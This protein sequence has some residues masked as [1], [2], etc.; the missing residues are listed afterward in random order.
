MIGF[1]RDR[2]KIQKETKE[3]G[4]FGPTSSW[5][6]VGVPFWAAMTDISTDGRARYQQ[7]GHSDVVYVIK[8]PRLLT[9]TIADHRVVWGSR[10]FRC[11]DP[12]QQ[13]GVQGS[14]VTTVAVREVAEDG[15]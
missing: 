2:I 11:V 9:L 7:L 6:D 10:Y 5:D 4:P 14:H 12:P 8:I 3:D 13:R 15:S 1:Y